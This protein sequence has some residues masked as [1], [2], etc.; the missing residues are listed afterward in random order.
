MVSDID[1]E[2]LEINN[3]FSNLSS[4]G[5]VLAVGAYLDDND[6]EVSDGQLQVMTNFNS[7]SS[8]VKVDNIEGDIKVMNSG[9]TIALSADGNIFAAS[10]WKADYV[11]ATNND[12]I[13]VYSWDAPAW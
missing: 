9:G 13:R 8:E 6:A 4:D 12:V 10:A 5:T 11:E 1:G 7:T 2:T 3:S